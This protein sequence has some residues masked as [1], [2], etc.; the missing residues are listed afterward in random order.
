[1]LVQTRHGEV[2]LTD[3]APGSQ[4]PL[5][6]VLRGMGDIWQLADLEVAGADVAFLDP[7]GVL[8]APTF[9]SYS[10]E[11]FAEAFDDVIGSR[12]AG[13]PV[14]LV[15]VSIGAAVALAMMSPQV[16]AV[17][18][19]EPFFRTAHLLPL[20]AF[21]R[22]FTLPAKTEEGRVFNEL[23]GYYPERVEDRA[24]EIQSKAP[25]YVVTGDTPLTLDNIGGAFPSFTGPSDRRL[26][27]ERGAKFLQIK[28]G[29]GAPVDD[30]AALKF[31]LQ[32]A[33]RE[34]IAP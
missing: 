8:G 22:Y 29:H 30:P 14:V 21:A 5:V 15:G 19:V 26:L 1:M 9:A 23:F 24:F 4:R 28:G 6:L 10:V 11:T 25:I 7:P 31:A 12:F 20:I 18:A 16:V 27:A 2:R 13:R 34:H 32:T 3:D 17:I 33:L